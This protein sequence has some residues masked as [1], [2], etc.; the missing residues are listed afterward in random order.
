MTKRVKNP[1]ELGAII[2][3]RKPTEV[4]YDLGEGKKRTELILTYMDGRSKISDRIASS[5]LIK[6][7]AQNGAVSMDITD[8]DTNADR[9][10]YKNLTPKGAVFETPDHPSYD[11]GNLAIDLGEGRQLGISQFYREK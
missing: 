11:L 9:Y 5:P 3:E 8:S 4:I 1:E 7:C 2:N 10:S 6:L